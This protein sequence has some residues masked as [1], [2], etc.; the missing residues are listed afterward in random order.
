V[1]EVEEVE[2]VTVVARRVQSSVVGSD[3]LN[4]WSKP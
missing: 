2:E 1:E 3:R 4:D